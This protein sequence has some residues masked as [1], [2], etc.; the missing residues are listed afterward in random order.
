MN[1]DTPLRPN[2]WKVPVSMLLRS[3]DSYVAFEC[4]N[5]ELTFKYREYDYCPY[6]GQAIDWSESC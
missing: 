1:R 3:E 5:C 2:K 6:C 4:A